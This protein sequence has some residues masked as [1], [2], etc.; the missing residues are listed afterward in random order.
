MPSPSLREQYI[1]AYILSII[2]RTIF[3]PSQS[4]EDLAQQINI[5]ISSI[6]AIHQ[7]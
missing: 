4:L 5:D 1:A 2:L 7:T 6:T 3:Q